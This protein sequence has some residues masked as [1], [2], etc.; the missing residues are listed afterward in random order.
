[1]R[2]SWVFARKEIREITRTWRIYVLPSILLLFAITGPVLA[3]YTPEL[4]SA[5]AGSQFATLN[6][7][8]PTAF[9]SYGQW[10]KNLSQMASFAIIVIYGG[11]VSAERRS[12][13]AVLVLSKSLSR[14]AFVLVKVVVQVFYV[15]VLLVGA[16][17]VTW[18]TTAVV[19][20]AAPGA[21]LWSA[22]FLWLV[23]AILYLS[24]MTL[25]SVLIPS[26]AGAA[27]A[28]LGT[29]MVL[30]IASLSKGFR[31][32]S[33]AGIPEQAASLASGASMEFPLWPITSSVVLSVSVVALAAAIF[34]RQ[35]L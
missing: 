8:K 28:G 12:G 17:F 7:P 24:L 16:T 11:I 22:V 32:Y 20:G 25:F 33:P 27:G 2:S 10:V 4:L 14:V 13:T 29:F 6:L 5:V 21:A 26:A 31:E 9:D 23:A 3:K 34:R 19:F 18:G 15:A 1:M 35:E 30:S